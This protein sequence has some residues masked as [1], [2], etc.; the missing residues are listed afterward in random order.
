M[1]PITTSSILGMDRLQIGITMLLVSNAPSFFGSTVAAAIDAR[2]ETLPIL[3]Y[4]R[5]A[6]FAHLVGSL[7]LVV[8]RMKLGKN[9]PTKA[10]E[11]SNNKV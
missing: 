7:L 9:M 2:V 6:G 10:L 1:S 8:L 5:F 4:K 3:V 11:A